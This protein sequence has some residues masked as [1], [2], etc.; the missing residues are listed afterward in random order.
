[1][2]PCSS[3]ITLLL[4]TQPLFIS[5]L[6]HSKFSSIP[7]HRNHHEHLQFSLTDIHIWH[8]PLPFGIF[9]SKVDIVWKTF[10]LSSCMVHGIQ[11]HFFLQ[12]YET[13]ICFF[14]ELKHSI[15]LSSK[16]LFQ[17]LYSCLI[18]CYELKVITF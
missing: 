18:L 16:L 4:K 7:L 15:I 10:I 13:P 17:Q 11:F 2:F 14:G 12:L 5:R 6:M 3:T 1:V 8:V 9:F